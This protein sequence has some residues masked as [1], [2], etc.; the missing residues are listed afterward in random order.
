MHRIST[1][2]S[3]SPHHRGREFLREFRG[4]QDYCNLG[5]EFIL[6][7]FF[8]A[9]MLEYAPFRVPLDPV[10]VEKRLVGADR[11]SKC[12]VRH[13]GGIPHGLQLHVTT[14]FGALQLHHQ[15]ARASI[16]TQKVH[17]S[18]AVFPI[19]IFFRQD[20]GIRNE[21]PDRSLEYALQVPAFEN[22]IGVERGLFG[23]RRVASRNT[24]DHHSAVPSL[25]RS[26]A[27]VPR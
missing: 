12:H 27:T 19:A 17:A 21:D 1:S 24:I 7:R 14:V 23:R 3:D 26:F 6:L 4:R 16:E 18:A 10:F 20:Q 8:P 13:H 9:Q 15:E 11:L 22:P 2:W 25:C 5:R